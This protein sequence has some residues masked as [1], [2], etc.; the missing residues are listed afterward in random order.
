MKLFLLT[1]LFMSLSAFGQQKDMNVTVKNKWEHAKTDEPVVIDLSKIKNLNFS[2][3]SALVTLNGKE[4]PSQLDDMNGDFHADELVFLTDIGGKDVQKFK[5]TLKADG[6][7]KKYEQRVYADMMLDDKKSKHPFITSIEAPGESY[8]YSD[9]YHHGAAFESEYTAFRVYFDHRQNIDIYGKKL[10]RLEL[11]DTHFYTTPEQMGQNYG[12]D[13]LWAGN[14]IGCG[15]FKN[16]NGKS[17]ENMSEVATRGQRIISAGPLR[18]VIEVKDMGWRKNNA[19]GDYSEK[20]SGATSTSLL[21]M[22]QYYILY[23]GHRECEVRITFDSALGKETFC[24]GVQKV[25]STPKGFTKDNGIAASWGSDYPE[26]GKKDIFPPETVGLAVYVPEKFIQE[27]HTDEL[28]YLF[29]VGAEGEKSIR[30]YVT[31]CADKEEKGIHSADEW[32]TSLE[33]WRNSL[34]NPV[35]IKISF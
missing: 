15:S 10:Y 9:L 14:S 23:G 26:M 22:K 18:T 4:I 12:N 21:N 6:E 2:V 16:W 19:T 25:G 35:E 27:Q 30:Y 28:N 17:P 3:K 5:V 29:V 32:F 11:S 13:V 7:Q 20:N 24:T 34:T 33:S 31:F 8:I 1:S